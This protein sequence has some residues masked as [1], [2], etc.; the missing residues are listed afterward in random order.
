MVSTPGEKSRSSWVRGFVLPACVAAAVL[1]F[2]LSIY[3][4]HHLSVPLGWDTAAYI[5]ITNLSRSIG[6]HAAEH[7]S[8]AAQVQA[9]PGRP[10]FPTV[11]GVL[12]SLGNVSPI[13]LIAVIPAAVAASIGLAGGAIVAGERRRPAWSFGVT[14]FAVALSP[15]VLLLVGPTGYQDN[16]LATAVFLT[17]IVAIDRAVT[18][19]GPLWPAILLFG[20]GGLIHWAFFIVMVAVLLLTAVLWA[21]R[22]L[23]DV[24]AGESVLQTPAGRIG[25]IVL[26]GAAMAGALLIGVLGALPRAPTLTFADLKRKFHALLPKYRVWLTVPIGL[27]GLGSLGVSDSSSAWTQPP[28][29]PRPK[30]RGFLFRLLV[31]W[32]AVTLAGVFAYR[33]LH[34]KV[35]AQRFLAFDMA[36]PLAG[37]MG[38]LWASDLVAR[39]A[40][41][42]PWSRVATDA[43]VVLVLL[44]LAFTTLRQ[45]YHWHAA[46]SPAT[47][48]QSATAGSYLDAA[49][50]SESRPVVFLLDAGD[51]TA[52]TVFR[53]HL[54]RAG[55]PAERIAQAYFYVGFP[56][57]FLAREPSTRP[58]HPIFD[59]TSARYLSRLGPAYANDP[60]ALL[61]QSANPAF[62]AWVA[63]HPG[64]VVGPGVAVVRGPLLATPLG[65]T[66]TPVEPFTYLN[67]AVL[68]AFVMGTLFLVGLGWSVAL[69]GGDPL[70]V[71]AVA[72]SV[73]I[74]A[75]VP[76]A[77][78]A[79]RLG[80]R[81]R[82]AGGVALPIVV[83]ACGWALAWA[84][85]RR[86]RDGDRPTFV[87]D[88]EPSE[89][90]AARS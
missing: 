19:D 17:A 57:Q 55:V 43:A 27:L 8:T 75:L 12:A 56:E 76:F 4:R 82:G 86:N 34:L 2:Y 36:L 26:G 60:V 52:T 44:V 51:D 28:P 6:L 9:N 42:I 45:W 54:I 13:R 53:A 83:A 77:V 78:V 10:G 21:R 30:G 29:F 81:L 74:A 70:R 46:I 35:P 72:P 49:K 85:S 25:A 20:A 65:Q 22:S 24:R 84:L 41:R 31:A 69:L 32:A 40:R 64:T 80:L 3:P 63:A 14:A 48:E 33:G 73:G 71:V 37:A 50:I 11:A 90:S 18:G 5:W 89:A 39:W 38:L 16:L 7:L 58:G 62:D 23:A 1:G 61:L 68:G 88:A 67:L 15:L 87:G 59:E 66:P 79:D 47:L